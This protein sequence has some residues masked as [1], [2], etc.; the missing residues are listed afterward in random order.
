MTVKSAEFRVFTSL[1]LRC[2]IFVLQIHHFSPLAL[3]PDVPTKKRL[4]F[5]HSTPCSVQHFG[6]R[7]QQIIMVQ[8]ENKKDKGKSVTFC[9]VLAFTVHAACAMLVI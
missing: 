2:H 6:Q 4:L 5:S 8:T 3:A 7:F 1:D 9:F